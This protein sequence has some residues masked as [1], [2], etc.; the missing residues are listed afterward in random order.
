M[1]AA[2]VVESFM[3]V[4]GIHQRIFPALYVIK[5]MIS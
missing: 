4:I 5:D 3:H 1:D 2:I